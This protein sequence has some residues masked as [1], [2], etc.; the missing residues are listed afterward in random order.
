VLKGLY[1]LLVA[2]ISGLCS[3]GSQTRTD[4]CNSLSSEGG[5]STMYDIHACLCGHEQVNHRD[6]ED[7][8]YQP[9]SICVLCEISLMSCASGRAVATHGSNSL[10]L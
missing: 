6:L 4:R 8:T 5:L 2:V 9:G 3:V 1:A 10:S 7:V